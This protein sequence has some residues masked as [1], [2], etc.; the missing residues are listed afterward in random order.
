MSK[1]HGNQI[2]MKTLKTSSFK[3]TSSFQRSNSFR[4]SSDSDSNPDGFLERREE[5]V[6]FEEVLLKRRRRNESKK[7]NWKEL[8]LKQAKK[9]GPMWL[10]RYNYKEWLLG[11]VLA[12]ITVGVVAVPQ[13]MAYSIIVGL[14]PIYGLYSSFI[15]LLVFGLLG[16]SRETS[17]GPFALISLLASEALGKVATAG[18]PEYVQFAF[19]LTFIVGIMLILMGLFRLGFLVNFMSNPVLEGF[20]FASALV[21]GSSQLKYLF[22]VHPPRADTFHGTMINFFKDIHHTNWKTLCI[23]I[24]FIVFLLAIKE[25]NKHLA[26]R[27]I[28]IPGPLLVLIIGILLGWALD[29][30]VKHHVDLVGEIPK[31]PPSPSNPIAAALPISDGLENLQI[32]LWQGLILSVVSFM[33]TIS[34]AKKYSE[35][36]KYELNVNQELIALGA[37]N[38]VG[39][40][41]QGFPVAGSLS[42]TVVNVTSGAR[43]QLSGLISAVIVLASLFFLTSI[44]ALLPMTC[45]AAIVIVAVIGLANTD[46]IIDIWK[47]KRTDIALWSVAFFSTLALGIANG[48]IWSIGASIVGAIY[49]ESKPPIVILGRLPNSVTYRS[50]MRFPQA[51]V[52]PRMTIIRMD[53]SLFFANINFL[54]D[55][56]YSMRIKERT[57]CI[58]M[59]WSSVNDNDY[60]AC[61]VFKM[62]VK[63]LSKDNIILLL[64]SIKGQVRDVLHR[65]GLV[66]EIGTRNILW[67]LD[68]AVQQGL[69][70]MKEIIPQPEASP[71]M[72]EESEHTTINLEENETNLEDKGLLTHEPEEEYSPYVFEN[73]ETS[74]NTRKQMNT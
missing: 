39:S 72:T 22:G 21:I 2:E 37:S 23:G 24:F 15:P 63:D 1:T 16:T 42:R 13:G 55:T 5:E 8:A 32:L 36:R 3:R 52:I 74:E 57:R 45:L 71:Q 35:E 56:L 49:S 43:T 4:N 53:A 61:R 62:M 50:I 27:K 18:T 44:L 6:S 60:T 19:L 33:L 38:L 12:G 26:K 7:R 54:K 17:V 70:L 11:D 29:L 58:V 51:L 20:Q 73:H 46:A 31:G 47:I 25:I 34:V 48:I 28:F 30:D 9:V 68:D 69:I 40:F 59:D 10:I 66:E 41:F 64:S 14:D 67:E 65:S